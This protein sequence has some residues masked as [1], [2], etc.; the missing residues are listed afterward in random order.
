MGLSAWQDGGGGQGIL[1]CPAPECRA[2]FPVIDGLPVLVADLPRFLNEAGIYLLAREDLFEPIADLFGSVL[3]PGSW[4]DATRQHLSGYVRDHWGSCDP[5]DRAAPAPGQAWGLAQAGLALAGAVSGPV[6]ELGAAAGGVTRALAD[7]FDTPVLGIDLSA[8]LARFAARALRGGTLRYP[9]RLAGTAYQDRQITIPP[10]Q[11]DNASFWLADAMVPPLE[12]GCAG[13]VVALNLLDVVSDPAA[14][15]RS[16]AALL[17]PGG[18]L[19]L[20]TPFD[21]STAAT[22]VAAW[23]GA[24]SVEAAAPDVGRWAEQVSGLDVVGRNP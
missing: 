3:P 10:P 4:F 2:R 12:P 17:R 24:R 14:L 23:L 22:P 15:L 21:W 11:R 19:L 1:D 6:V 18:H 5:L 13:L 20:C 7:R 9:L 8:P 16:A